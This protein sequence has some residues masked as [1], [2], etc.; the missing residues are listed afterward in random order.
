MTKEFKAIAND[1]RLAY[2][3]DD[4]VRLLG[5]NRSAIYKA[6]SSGQLR[7]FKIGRRRLI[8]RRAIKEYIRTLEEEEASES[9]WE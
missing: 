1:D 5:T 8:S 2:S 9:S 7:S 6:I 3:V 4:V